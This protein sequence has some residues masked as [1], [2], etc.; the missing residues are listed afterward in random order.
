MDE[1]Q[2]CDKQQHGD[3]KGE[4]IERRG[5]VRQRLM[6]SDREE[7]K[8]VKEGKEREGGGQKEGQISLF[9]AACSD[10]E[11]YVGTN[12]PESLE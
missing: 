9:S 1:G 8:Q 3:E 4:E 6:W 2:H 7:R 11:R 5:C 12:V 10:T